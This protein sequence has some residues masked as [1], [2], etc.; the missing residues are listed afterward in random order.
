MRL[1]ALALLAT[2][3]YT[4]KIA[5][6][7]IR[8]GA[9]NSCPAETSCLVDHFC[10]ADLGSSCAKLPDGGFGA[11]DAR[12]G[13][14]PIFAPDARPP[15][16]RRSPPDA[17]PPDGPPCQ[18]LVTTLDADGEMLLSNLSI[19]GDDV[20][21]I[22][23]LDATS[24][25]LLYLRGTA[26]GFAPREHVIEAGPYLKGQT[27]DATGAVHVAFSVGTFPD[28]RLRYAHRTPGS[29]GQWSD[30]T[31]SEQDSP[32][33]ASIVVD[34][35]G[36]PQVAYYAQEIGQ[37]W[38]ARRAD[39]WLLD[40]IDD[41]GANDVGEHPSL[42]LGPG[43]GMFVTYRN[44]TAGQLKVAT[45]TASGWSVRLLDGT[46]ADVGAYSAL[47]IDAGGTLHVAYADLTRGVLKYL[48]TVPGGTIARKVIDDTD[49]VGRFNAIA[50]DAHGGVHISSDA[51]GQDDLHYVH[52]APGASAFTVVD[53]DQVG[54]VGRHTGIGVD[55]SGSAH[56]SY[57]DD[58][59]HALKYAVICPGH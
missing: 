36:A 8:C 6:C 18:D 59:N 7:T 14:G 32:I 26:G 30:E 47:A 54:S 55:S 11:V 13:D 39:R 49:A 29:D 2:A 57:I 48:E 53:V 50:L 22:T 44:V 34:D 4:P 25:D 31:I 20:V 45:A 41:G 52:R 21:H 19:D 17:G 42:A 12:T 9:D 27:V 16:A 5:E 43:G 33:D 1:A 56:I 15:D 10:H 37:L 28:I 23:Y 51:Y 35:S 3:C 40:T 38:H 24:H 58:T 46:S